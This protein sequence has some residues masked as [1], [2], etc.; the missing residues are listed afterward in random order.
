MFGLS[1]KKVDFNSPEEVLKR[2]AA[3]LA[4]IEEA[5]GIS[6]IS[7]SF[8]DNDRVKKLIDKVCSDTPAGLSTALGMLGLDKSE[9]NLSIAKD[10][11][12]AVEALSKPKG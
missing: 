12:I 5:F 10:V 3:A 7:N 11:R 8:C 1:K 2:T 6:S 9:E 4:I